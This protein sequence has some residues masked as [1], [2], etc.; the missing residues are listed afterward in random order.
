MYYLAAIFQSVIKREGMQMKQKVR[1]DH[2]LE[3]FPL[4][5]LPITLTDEA[6]LLFSK[7]N[8]PL[9]PLMIEQYILP[10]ESDAVDEF[11]EFIPCFRLKDTFDIQA[12]VYWRAQLMQYE[13]CMVTFSKKGEFIDKRTI[14]GTK[15]SG[16]MLVKSVATIDEDWIIY[17]VG[18]AASAAEESYDASASQS[19]N[20]ELL[21]DGQIIVSK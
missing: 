1:F 15:V 8:E 21:A 19:I 12:I 14:A 11:T 16:D 6:P 5:D 7:N 17:V 20:F 10:Y 18:G 3:K 13:Y 9:P 4:I 2:F